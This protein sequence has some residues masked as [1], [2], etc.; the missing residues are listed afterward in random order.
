M[1]KRGFRGEDFAMKKTVNYMSED[2]WDS[3]YGSSELLSLMHSRPYMNSRQKYKLPLG[4]S[5]GMPLVED[6]SVITHLLITGVPSGGKTTLIHCLLT[7]LMMEKESDAFAFACYDSR[8]S[9][10]A[11]YAEN[12]FCMF[13]FDRDDPVSSLKRLREKIHKVHKAFPKMEMVIVLDDYAKLLG[14]SGGE[15]ALIELLKLG[16]Y[17]HAHA[18]LVTADIS[19]AVVTPEIRTLVSNRISFRAPRDAAG[20]TGIRDTEFLVMPGEAFVFWNGHLCRCNTVY[21]DNDE[22][23]SLN[24]EIIR[25][26]ERVLPDPLDDLDSYSKAY[27]IDDIMSG[28]NEEPEDELYKEAVQYVISSQKASTAILQKHFGISTDRAQKLIDLLEERGV[29]GPERASMPRAV[30]SWRGENDYRRQSSEDSQV[31]HYGKEQAV[32]IDGDRIRIER[33]SPSVSMNSYDVFANPPALSEE[34]AVPINRIDKVTFK[35]AR[36]S[37]GY[38]HIYFLPGPNDVGLSGVIEDM[39]TGKSFDVVIPFSDEKE[40]EFINFGRLLMKKAKSL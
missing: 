38:I 27:S 21:A 14:L 19:G 20:L 6:L 24:H 30:Y 11:F 2:S 13:L 39:G 31:R 7:A 28:G 22:I 23:L 10:Y 16:T 34:I 1:R 25:T 3:A 9:E 40:D 15:A 5:G 26:K 4:L 32:W 33:M 36:D 37:H 35:R 12:P 8:K 17:E 18:F 29:I